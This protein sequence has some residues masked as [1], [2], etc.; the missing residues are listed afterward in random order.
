MSGG[1]DAIGGI[2]DKA[3]SDTSMAPLTPMTPFEKKPGHALGAIS[4]TPK[5]PLM[6]VTLPEEKTLVGAPMKHGDA[7]AFASE[8]FLN[9]V[10]ATAKHYGVPASCLALHSPTGTYLKARYGAL[11]SYVPLP[12][13]GHYPMC[14][15]HV[16]R[17]VPVIIEDTLT[18][19]R[20]EQDLL[21]K[22]EPYVRF[23]AGAPLKQLNKPGC[24]LGALCIFDSQP[25]VFSADDADMLQTLAFEVS[26]LFAKM[27]EGPAWSVTLSSAELPRISPGYESDL[28][29]DSDSDDDR[30][31]SSRSLPGYDSELNLDTEEQEPPV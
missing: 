17:D 14:R 27:S 11:P 20:V 9:L 12:A 1:I 6:P 16:N 23:Y 7:E 18:C 13:S 5:A 31:S 4:H 8:S 3:V 21:V 28:D 25:R 29:S 10:A 30:G 2:H 26:V 24:I 22:E 19:K 15:H